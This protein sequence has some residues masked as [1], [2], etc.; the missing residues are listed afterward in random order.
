M[1]EIC[2]FPGRF[3]IWLYI[4][5]HGQ[6]L[7]RSTKTVEASPPPPFVTRVRGMS[8]PERFFGMKTSASTTTPAT[9]RNP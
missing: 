3:Q 4:V 6:L 2:S 9:L 5:S 7:L 8:W 1:T